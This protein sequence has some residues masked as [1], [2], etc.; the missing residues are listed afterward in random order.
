[1][2]WTSERRRVPPDPCRT[3]RRGFIERILTEA[4]WRDAIP[5]QGVRITGAMVQGE[6]ALTN[7][8]VGVELAL[9]GSR[10]TDGVVLDRAKLAPLVVFDGSRLGSLRAERVEVANNVWLRD[11]IVTGPVILLN[12]TIGNQ[13][14]LSGSRFVQP[15]S[16][17][18]ARLGGWLEM[19]KARFNHRYGS[20]PS[21]LPAI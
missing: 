11:A 19:N 13:V 12:A 20:T 16:L 17:I 21:A 15:V 14:V 9:T 4:P 10:L 18:G 3:L 5:R 6:I 7:A 8:T 1:M 2:R